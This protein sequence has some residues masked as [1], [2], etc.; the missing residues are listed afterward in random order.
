MSANPM[1]S[2]AHLAILPVARDDFLEPV[3]LDNMDRVT[4][5]VV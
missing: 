3:R 4:F 5:K 1:S 2:G